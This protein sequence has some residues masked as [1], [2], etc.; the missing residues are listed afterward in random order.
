MGHFSS[1]N[2]AAGFE[3]VLLL[4]VAFTITLVG[5]LSPQLYRRLQEQD[6]ALARG[7]SPRVKDQVVLIVKTVVLWVI[8]YR[9]E[10]RERTRFAD[11]DVNWMDRYRVSIVF[12]F[13]PVYAI[14]ILAL[15]VWTR[16]VFF[17]GHAYHTFK[18]SSDLSKLFALF[19]LYVGS[20]IFF[21]FCSLRITFAHFA[22]AQKTG[23][24]AFYFARNPRPTCSSM[25]IE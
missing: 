5:L 19:I 16:P 20:N 25:P 8:G 14:Y 18:Y 2:W 23:R 21:D 9:G 10:G 13:I 3:Q 4:Y 11:I 22:L 1:Y 15:L 7:H 17:D 24:Y 12:R 6:F